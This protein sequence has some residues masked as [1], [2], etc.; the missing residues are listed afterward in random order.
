MVKVY[1]FEGNEFVDTGNVYECEDF[2]KEH[3][4]ALL[5]TLYT[6]IKE[7]CRIDSGENSPLIQD[8]FQ[9]VNGNLAHLWADPIDG[10][11]IYIVRAMDT[12]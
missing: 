5:I 12:Q 8:T 7:N 2:T 6:D 9:L 3:I 11:T 4:I 10:G 1:I